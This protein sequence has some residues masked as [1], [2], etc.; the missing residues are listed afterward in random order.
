MEQY[1]VCLTALEKSIEETVGLF[2]KQN[3]EEGFRLID[4]TFAKI[5]EIIAI[6][7]NK[8]NVF[9]TK[10]MTINELNNLLVKIMTSL[11]E[12]DVI[13]LCDL[14]RYELVDLLKSI[15]IE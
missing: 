7:Y 6:L 5:E 4:K 2:Y 15:K 14:L 9:D 12:R 13:V 8:D 1:Y 11:E 10:D 3:T